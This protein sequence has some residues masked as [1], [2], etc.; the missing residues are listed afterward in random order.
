[1]AEGASKTNPLRGPGWPATACPAR[2]DSLLANSFPMRSRPITLPAAPNPARRRFLRN[3]VVAV[4]ATCLP[5]AFA[6]LPTAKITRIRVY[7]PPNLNIHFN[8]SNMVVT[9]ETDAGITG[10]GEGGARD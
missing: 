2:R 4:T 5:R 8:Q 7:Q 3:L 1:M 9:I 10:V 6:A